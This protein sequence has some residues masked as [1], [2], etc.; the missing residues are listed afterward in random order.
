MTDTQAEAIA[1]MVKF[2]FIQVV[3]RAEALQG[4]RFTSIELAAGL[5]VSRSTV[6]QWFDMS[7]GHTDGRG[8]T[9]ESIDKICGFLNCTPADLF[10]YEPPPAD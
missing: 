6:A 2:Q 4:D 1:H 7:K 5:G 3:G 8:I 10:T 9:L